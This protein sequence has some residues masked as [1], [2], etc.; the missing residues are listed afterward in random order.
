M[1][2]Q[3]AHEGTALLPLHRKSK[4]EKEQEQRRKDNIAI[5]VNFA[6]NVV[7]LAAKV[8]VVLFSNSL[9]LLASAVDSFM[10]FLSTCIIFF[11]ARASGTRDVYNV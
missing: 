5:N 11:T 9:S 3:L 10:D 4:V 6:V 2:H 1:S 8:L 7:L